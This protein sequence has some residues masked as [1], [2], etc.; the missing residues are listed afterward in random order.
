MGFWWEAHWNCRCFPLLQCQQ[1]FRWGKI[2]LWFYF[3]IIVS[4]QFLKMIQ[5]RQPLFLAVQVSG[6]EGILQAYVER[7]HNVHLNGPTLFGPVIHKAASIA[8]E[9]AA[10]KMQ[11]YY[12]LM[13]ITVMSSYSQFTVQHYRFK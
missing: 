11:K 7:I 3:D 4:P 10:R 8:Q 5:W 13:I 1:A 6:V 12:V 9:S 2:I